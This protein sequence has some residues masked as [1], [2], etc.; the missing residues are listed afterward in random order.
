VL[1]DEHTTVTE[2]GR[3]EYELEEIFVSIVEGTRPELVEGGENG[4]QQ[5]PTTG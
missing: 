3:K 5:H 2:F 1:A 4:K